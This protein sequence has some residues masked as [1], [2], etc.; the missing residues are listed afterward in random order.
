[1]MCLIVEDRMLDKNLYFAK[2][3]GAIG[4]IN[5]FSAKG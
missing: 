5:E 3:Y 4:L 2:G 1:M